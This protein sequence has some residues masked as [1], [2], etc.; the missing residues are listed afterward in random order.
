MKCSYVIG[1][2]RHVHIGCHPPVAIGTRSH[3]LMRRVPHA[4]EIVDIVNLL[5]VNV[6]VREKE[7]A[8]TH[9]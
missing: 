3:V 5:D 1:C 2:H 4:L 6:G 7:V 8:T 9:A